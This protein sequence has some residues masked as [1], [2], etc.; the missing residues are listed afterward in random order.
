MFMY[1]HK[2]L[3]TFYFL[4]T[5]LEEIQDHE[6]S[7]TLT[8]DINF[9]FDDFCCCF[10]KVFRFK[11]KTAKF[12]MLKFTSQ[13]LLHLMK[14]FHILQSPAYFPSFVSLCVPRGRLRITFV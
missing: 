10:E 1:V 3:E 12:K 13:L 14:H 4:E 11:I 7:L 9:D 6:M 5:N 8:F 2:I